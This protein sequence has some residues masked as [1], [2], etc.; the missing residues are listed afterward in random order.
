MPEPSQLASL[1]LRRALPTDTTAV[2][3]CVLQAYQPWVAKIG[4]TPGP[5][6]DD[7][8]RVIATS[9]VYLAESPPILAGILVLATTGEG[10]L[11]ENVAVMPA[12]QG[13]GV[14][15]LLLARAE[16]EARLAGYDSIYLYTHEKMQRN[17]ELYAKI[18]YV[19]YARREEIGLR[20]V[21]MRKRLD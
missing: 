19:E 21:F 13:S 5:L 12:Y 20:R 4:H 11:L 17:I 2:T 9:T 18:G 10:F 16:H 7:Y 8:A 1:R 6:L 15:R 3:A 14:G